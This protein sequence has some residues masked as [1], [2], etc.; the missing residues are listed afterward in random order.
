MDLNPYRTPDIP[1]RIV[2]DAYIGYRF[3]W[4]DANWRIALNVYNLTDDTVSQEVAEY[5]GNG[6]STEYRRTRIYHNPRSFRIS[7]T[8][9]F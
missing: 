5:P 4:L 9:Y 3:S 6:S 2:A 8:V 7:A 1:E